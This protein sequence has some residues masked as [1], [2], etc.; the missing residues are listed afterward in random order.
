MPQGQK[1]ADTD[2]FVKWS[3]VVVE[4]QTVVGVVACGHDS[5]SWLSYSFPSAPDNKKQSVPDADQWRDSSVST[6]RGRTLALH[7][8]RRWNNGTQEGF[9]NTIPSFYDASGRNIITETAGLGERLWRHFCI[10]LL[11]SQSHDCQHHT[12]LVADDLW[13]TQESWWQWWRRNAGIGWDIHAVFTHSWTWQQEVNIWSDMVTSRKA[14]INFWRLN[15]ALKP[16][17]AAPVQKWK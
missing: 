2:P 5:L 4:H 1:P 7:P 14:K 3:T 9:D 11:C 8:T 15:Q 16:V 13:L 12:A 17:R 6:N 10:Q